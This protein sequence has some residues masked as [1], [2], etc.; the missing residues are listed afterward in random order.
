MGVWFKQ[1]IRHVG[2]LLEKCS[3]KFRILKS[4]NGME[5]TRICTLESLVTLMSYFQG[6]YLKSLKSRKSM[7]STRLWTRAICAI[8]I[9]KSSGRF[10]SCQS[11]ITS[12]RSLSKWSTKL[13]KDGSQTTNRSWSWLD[14]TSKCQI[15]KSYTKIAR[16]LRRDLLDFLWM[17]WQTLKSLGW[18]HTRIQ[19]HS[20]TWRKM[21]F[22]IWF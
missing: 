7:S 13:T 4:L 12:A 9:V 14:S 6:G 3:L 17:R 2:T 18:N 16:S 11:T 15:S 1:L 19:R 8:F 5:K 10:C 20:A 21:I 22:Q